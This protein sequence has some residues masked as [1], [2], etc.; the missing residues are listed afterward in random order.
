MANG[1]VVRATA[2]II[3]GTMGGTGKSTVSKELINTEAFRAKFDEIIII[4]GGSQTM[5]SVQN[6]K[7]SSFLESLNEPHPQGFRGACFRG[8]LWGGAWL[9]HVKAQ[10]ASAVRRGAQMVAPGKTYEVCIV[11]SRYMPGVSL[12]FVESLMGDELNWGD[13][14][15]SAYLFAMEQLRV[16]MNDDFDTVL[17]IN[18]DS[19]YGD[20]TGV[21]LSYQ[22]MVARLR[23]DTPRWPTVESWRK[24]FSRRMMDW[25]EICTPIEALEGS[26]QRNKFLQITR[27]GRYVEINFMDPEGK[28]KDD[29]ER[30]RSTTEPMLSLIM[31]HLTIL[32]HMVD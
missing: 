9:G 10:L 15:P 28:F 26:T 12:A 25:G 14:I 2:V 21:D 24:Q 4:D 11:T 1:G 20:I 6:H 5:G 32:R 17:Y 18:M 30:F 3:T 8:T 23:F 7:A 22:R 19:F 29:L 27:K 16:A 13:P 31:A